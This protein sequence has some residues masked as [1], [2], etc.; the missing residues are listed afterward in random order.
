MNIKHLPLQ[1]SL[2]FALAISGAVCQTPQAQAQSGN[3]SDITGVII[4]TSDVA[5]SFNFSGGGGDRRRLIAFASPGIQSSV[6]SAAISINQQLQ[7]Q[8]LAVV[9]TDASQAAVSVTIQQTLLI[10][11]TNTTNVDA[12][13]TQFVNGLV[14]AG[15]EANVSRN[16]V[17]SMVGLTA[18][19]KV[20]AAQC[21]RVIR[22]YNVFI[23]N[24]TVELLTNNPDELRAI[25]SVLAQ[26]LN[27]AYASR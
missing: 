20:E 7:Q 15:A 16:L 18:K 25:R 10:I 11:L 24:S 27:A 9:A 14:N 21:Q 4:T 26:L 13:V 2:G 22:S 19:G 3:Q 5:G 8:S 12:R 17:L 23:E 6:N 1:L